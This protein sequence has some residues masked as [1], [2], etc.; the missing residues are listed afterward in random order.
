MANDD[1]VIRTEFSGFTVVKKPKRSA[2][3]L[4]ADSTTPDVAELHRHYGSDSSEETI[5][6]KAQPP[7]DPAATHALVIEPQNAGDGPGK[8]LTVLV[9]NGK[10]RAKQG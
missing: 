9:K 4:P 8:R 3:Y 5:L 1:D 6:E 7:S 2:S 10:V